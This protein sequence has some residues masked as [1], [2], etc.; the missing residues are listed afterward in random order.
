M[1]WTPKKR[2]TKPQVTEISLPRDYLEY[3][4]TMAHQPYPFLLDSAIRDE[5]YGRF[6]L[7]GSSPFLM[8]THRDSKTT[9][10]RGGRKTSVKGDPIPLID[11]LL[12]AFAVPECPADVPF[13]GCAVGYFGYD[14]GRY[15]ET[16]PHNAQDDLKMADLFLAFYDRYVCVDHA[17]KKSF[18][19]SVDFGEKRITEPG[20]RVPQSPAQPSFELVLES[21]FTRERYQEM[22]RKAK[23]YIAA[24]DI[25][26]VNLSQRFHARTAVHPFKVFQNLRKVSPAPYTAYLQCGPT[27]FISSS[28]E[29]FLE[30]RGR[31]AISRPI[32]GTRRRGRDNV[33]DEA[34]RNE[35]LASPKDDA[36]LNMIIDLTRNDLGKVCEFGSVKVAQAKTLETWPTVH[37]LSA[38]VEGTLRKE[39]PF[40]D[41]F[42]ALFPG[43][44]ITGAP[45]IRAM[46]IIDEMEPTRRGPYTGA[47]GWLGFDG[48]VN[49]AM[50]I[51]IVLSEKEN[52]YFQVGGGIV[53]DSDPDA[54]YEETLVKAEGILQSLELK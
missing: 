2:P 10:V 37:H 23:E 40:G 36:E 42:R 47:F 15:I 38:V 11:D 35:L 32:K 41:V 1:E 8:L 26:Q 31:R 54:E 34:L 53:A 17:R 39:C 51:R 12:K 13:P 52:L 50:A 25:Y 44:S 21:N 14:L 48:S 20:H 43:G 18:I 16:L 49:L 27:T 6:S 3:F 5:H 22:V 4:A 9:I 24:G 28:P 45:K 29:Q 46:E 7:M 19:V 30:I 33:E